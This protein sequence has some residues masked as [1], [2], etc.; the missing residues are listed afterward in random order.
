MAKMR[1]TLSGTGFGMVLAVLALMGGLAIMLFAE[2]AKA[3]IV[4]PP[5]VNE[6]KT[7]VDGSADPLCSCQWQYLPP[8]EYV[9]FIY[10]DV[11]PTTQFFTT[12]PLHAT[13]FKI[14]DPGPFG[15]STGEYRDTRPGCADAGGYPTFLTPC[16]FNGFAHFALGGLNRETFQVWVNGPAYDANGVILFGTSDDRILV[17]MILKQG[18]CG[19]FYRCQFKIDQVIMTP[20]GVQYQNGLTMQTAA[21]SFP[22]SAT[23]MEFVPNLDPYVYR[24]IWGWLFVDDLP[25]TFAFST[26]F[27]SPVSATIKFEKRNVPERMFDSYAWNDPWNYPLKSSFVPEPDAASLL[28]AGLA[29]LL[30]LAWLAGKGITRD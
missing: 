21:F 16:A 10:P 25:K 4:L 23:F 29:G 18:P 22:A 14:V 8:Y 20:Q 1:N 26:V 7:C 3:Q 24:S 11:A 30:G 5:E 27:G 9:C 28:G 6:A 2:C 19:D 12:A 17:E 13:S 15:F